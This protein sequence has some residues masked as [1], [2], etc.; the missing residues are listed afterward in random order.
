[1]Q[2]GHLRCDSWTCFSVPMPT[3]ATISPSLSV[4]LAVRHSH[5]PSKRTSTHRFL[6]REA[7]QST[8]E[9][10][11]RKGIPQGSVKGKG[12]GTKDMVE[13]KRELWTFAEDILPAAR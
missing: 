4:C 9:S 11:Q 13:G 12:D 6:I 10:A 8:E 5:R 7:N 1:M 3:S 2:Y